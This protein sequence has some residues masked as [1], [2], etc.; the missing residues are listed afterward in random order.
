MERGEAFLI[1]DS[2][3]KHQVTPIFFR[4]DRW[5]DKNYGFQDVLIVR[6]QPMGR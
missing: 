3:L 6:I 5:P 2:L 4:A 1:K